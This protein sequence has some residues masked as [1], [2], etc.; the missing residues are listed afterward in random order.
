MRWER[1]LRRGDHRLG[2]ALWVPPLP[3]DVRYVRTEG[4]GQSG[5]DGTREPEFQTQGG[6]TSAWVGA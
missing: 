5:Q 2:G 3:P 1:R 6:L 4:H